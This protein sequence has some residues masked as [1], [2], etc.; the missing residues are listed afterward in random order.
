[1]KTGKKGFNSGNFE[2]TIATLLDAIY[3]PLNKTFVNIPGSPCR[4]PTGEPSTCIE[5]S[6]SMKSFTPL[7]EPPERQQPEIRHEPHVERLTPLSFDADVHSPPK[8]GVSSSRSVTLDD[9]V[10]GESTDL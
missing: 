1:M 6:S 9:Y 7:P 4:F 2:D 8:S 5:K 3:L 10:E